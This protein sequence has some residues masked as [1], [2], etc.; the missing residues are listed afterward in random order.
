MLDCA[1]P[2]AWRRYANASESE[3]YSTHAITWEDVAAGIML[4][5]GAVTRQ[6]LAV[7]GA[8]ARAAFAQP[9]YVDA[10]GCRSRYFIAQQPREQIGTSICAKRVVAAPQ[11]G[12]CLLRRGFLRMPR[13]QQCIG[14]AFM[15]ATSSA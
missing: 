10:A 14:A 3:Q 13:C 2:A 6:G 5:A 15:G 9:A 12:R 7:A 4:T 8:R 1:R 11:T